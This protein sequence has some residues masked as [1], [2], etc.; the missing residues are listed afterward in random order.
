MLGCWLPDLSRFCG[1]TGVKC[2]GPRFLTSPYGGPPS[3]VPS[4][5]GV[6]PLPTSKSDDKLTLRL[7]SQLLLSRPLL[8]L[9]VSTCAQ[10]MAPVGTTRHGCLPVPV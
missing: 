8:C 9:P 5:L 1:V 3:L 7:L 4:L 10:H 2:A 6:R